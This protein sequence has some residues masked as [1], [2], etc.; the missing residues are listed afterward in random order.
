LYDAKIATGEGVAPVSDDENRSDARHWHEYEVGLVGE[1]ARAYARALFAFLLGLGCTFVF[2]LCAG[3]LAEENLLGDPGLEDAI[4]NLT[5]MSVGVLMALAIVAWLVSAVASCVREVATSRALVRAAERGAPRSD[6]PAPEQVVSVTS[7]PAEQLVFFAWVTAALTGLLGVIGVFIVL[8][9]QDEESLVIFS[10]V[11]GYA[12]VMFLVGLAARRILTP[13]H[14]RRR[15]RIAEHWGELDKGKASRPA[16]QAR[17]KGKKTSIADRCVYAASV[18]ATL[19]FVALV[20]SLGMRCGRLPGGGHSECEEVTYSSFIESI[21]AWGFW[22][23]AALFPLAAI[24]AVIGVLLDW[25]QRRSERADLRELVAD[26][27]SA[28]PAADLLAYHAQRRM[29]PLALVGAAMSG[30]VLVFSL[31]SYLVGQGMGLGSEDVFAVYRT[32]ALIGVLVAVGM[33]VAALLGSGIASVRGREFRNVL[34]RRWPPMPVIG[35]DRTDQASSTPGTP[36]AT[37]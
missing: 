25:R 16:K 17:K 30:F 24:L 35:T 15:A 23:F 5:R 27:S 11:T 22:I 36:S 37:T 31:S 3:I 20:A 6:V 32:E 9:E 14:R 33:F 10:I 18:L 13:A 1:V 34:M 21:L 28:R 7:E 8:A 29:H 26:P 4:D 2:I 12:V 19:G